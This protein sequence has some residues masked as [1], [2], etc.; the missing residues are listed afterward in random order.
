MGTAPGVLAV[1]VTCG[2][3]PT[4]LPGLTVGTGFAVGTGGGVLLVTAWVPR[5][6]G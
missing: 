5:G 3:L 6:N 2:L 1:G 4:A